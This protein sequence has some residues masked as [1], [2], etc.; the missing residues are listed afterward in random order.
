MAPSQGMR[1]DA[2]TTSE[3]EVQESL[4]ILWSVPLLPSTIENVPQ[5][6]LEID[7]VRVPTCYVDS[8]SSGTLVSSSLARQIW[9]AEYRNTLTPVKTL[10][11]DVQ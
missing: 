3:A 4:D 2:R 10:F 7:Q 8:G 11:T 9:G 6:K 1:R 5:I